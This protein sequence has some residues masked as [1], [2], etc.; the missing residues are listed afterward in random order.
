MLP[1]E[2]LHGAEVFEGP[3]FP[4]SIDHTVQLILE[5]LVHQFLLVVPPC[6]PELRSLG[7]ISPQV[8]DASLFLI[9]AGEG[10][11]FLVPAD[12]LERINF[13]VYSFSPFSGIC[14]TFFV[15]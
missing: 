11:Q 1:A 2:A 9:A 4:Q 3:V 15:I 14:P 8:T 12:L 7:K 10:Q 6:G 13:T 5:I